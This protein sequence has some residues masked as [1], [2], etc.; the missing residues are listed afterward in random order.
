[1]KPKTKWTW[2]IILLACGTGLILLNFRDPDREYAA[3]PGMADHAGAVGLRCRL[4]RPSPEGAAR[5]RQGGSGDEFS[6]G[7]GGH[8]ISWHYTDRLAS[9]QAMVALEPGPGTKDRQTRGCN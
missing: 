3:P 2:A 6:S 5:Q 4:R 1:M 8:G 9:P 7:Q